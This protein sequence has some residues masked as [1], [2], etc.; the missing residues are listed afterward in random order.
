MAPTSVYLAEEV[1]A[2]PIEQRRTLAKLLMDSVIDDGRSDDQIRDDLRS[3]LE[4]LK[5]GRD[6]GMSF[7]EVFGEK[8]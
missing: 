6:P 8:L 4:D 5:S 7:E 3:R 2:L 1:L